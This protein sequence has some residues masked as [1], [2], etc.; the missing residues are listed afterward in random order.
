MSGY[1]AGSCRRLRYRHRY[2]GA[3]WSALCWMLSRT[4]R[5]DQAGYDVNKSQLHRGPRYVPSCQ[6]YQCWNREP[7]AGALTKRMVQ[8]IALDTS[9]V[10]LICRHDV[11]VGKMC[12]YSGWIHRIWQQYRCKCQQTSWVKRLVTDE[13]CNFLSTVRHRPEVLLGQARIGAKE[14]YAYIG[15]GILRA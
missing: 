14:S 9:Q 7:W 5:K 15:D 12:L 2:Y 13:V 3:E 8:V 1:S 10:V 6:R 4:E 11:V